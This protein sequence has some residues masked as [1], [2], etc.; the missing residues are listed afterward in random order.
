MTRRVS[1]RVIPA[2]RLAPAWAQLAAIGCLLFAW[3]TSATAQ[4]RAFVTEDASL[5]GAGELRLSFGGFCGRDYEEPVYGLEGTLLQAPVVE[6]DYGLGGVAEVQAS[7]GLKTLWIH[8]RSDAPLSSILDIPGDR[9]SAPQDIIVAT[10]VR[11]I[12]GR[13]PV[14][15]LAVRFATK[16]PNAGNESGLGSDTA[17]FSFMIAAAWRSRDWRLAANLGTAIVGD[18]SQ[19]GV[20]H[21]PTLYAVQVAR[22]LNASTDLVAEVSG[23]WLPGH[24]GR[25]GS[26]DRGDVRVGLRRGAGRWRVDASLVAG[27]TSI[28]AS[29]GVSAMVSR[30][31]G[32]F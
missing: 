17:D 13:G 6:A 4:V 31:F 19:I 30:R 3:P 14:P 12:R 15:E 11:I 25:P 21:D 5:L 32:P 7:G 23:A 2:R 24:A 20:Q 16:L 22:H 29:L 26:E 1:R 10:K 28:D 9:T 18:P 27:L 8:R